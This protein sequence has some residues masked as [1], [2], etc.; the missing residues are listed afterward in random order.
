[1]PQPTSTV[2]SAE[3][4]GKRALARTLAEEAGFAA[5][6]ATSPP[7]VRWLLCGGGRPVSTS[8]PAADYAVVLTEGRDLV[9]FPDIEASRVATEERFQEIGYEPLPF[10]W[11][12]GR[13]RALADVL[14]GNSCLGGAEL[15]ALVAPVRRVLGPNEVERYRAA[16][17]EVAAAL[18][19]TIENLTTKA[20]ELDVAGE[21]ASR[22]HRRGFFAPVLLVGGEHR[23]GVHRHPVPTSASL[24]RHA[25]LAVTAERNGLHVSMTRLVSFGRAPAE[26]VER[27]RAAAAV[28]VVALRGSRP[29]RTLGDVF[30]DVEA[31]YASH[32]F[33]GEWRGHH[34]GGL[35]GYLGREV[36]AVPGDPT[37]IPKSAAVAWNPSITGGAKSEDTALVSAGG[38]EVVTRTRELPE[39]D[40][41]GVMRPSITEL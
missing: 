12:E 40:L 16:G 33:P 30:V 5:L 14:D 26:L 31:A 9:L 32:G 27:S 39:W 24:G 37:P 2:S 1:V 17:A 25:L 10:P 38:V 7:T 29:G 23:Q 15:E 34:Q 28:D 6:V 21:L 19:E 13:E 41:D 20:T 36:F 35:T 11:H 22:V 18:V 4:T 3:A 8:G